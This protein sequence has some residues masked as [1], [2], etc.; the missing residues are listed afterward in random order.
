MGT[1]SLG[2]GVETLSYMQYWKNGLLYRLVT[3]ICT[4]YPTGTNHR[5]QMWSSICTGR[6][7]RYKCLTFVLGGASTRYKYAPTLQR[8]RGA[9]VPGGGTT[10][11]K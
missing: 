7:T 1:L 8:G 11:Y 6:D 2:V 5:V 9:F 4:R 10:Q 3:H